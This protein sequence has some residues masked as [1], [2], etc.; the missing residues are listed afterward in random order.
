MDRVVVSSRCSQIDPPLGVN[1]GSRPSTYL[2]DRLASVPIRPSTSPRPS[3]A[4]R[5]AFGRSTLTWYVIPLGG[6]LIGLP[7]ALAAI[8]LGT[9]ARRERH[10]AG[11]ARTATAAIAIGALGIAQMA[12]YYLIESLA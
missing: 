12:V 4:G 9:R 2:M 11:G 1:N 10:D 7:L 8:V 5:A 3:S 6:L